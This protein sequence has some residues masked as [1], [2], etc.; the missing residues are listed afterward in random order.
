MTSYDRD[1]VLV[2]ATRLLRDQEDGG[3]ATGVVAGADD[4]TWRRI[5]SDMRRARRRRRWMSI[6]A[7]QFGIGLG[8]VGVWAA[9]TGRL[10]TI[11]K[12]PASL[13]AAPRRNPPP[14]R[15]HTLAVAPAFAPEIGVPLLRSDES[16]VTTTDRLAPAR[17]APGRPRSV[18]PA[19][20][21][22]ASMPVHAAEAPTVAQET[23]ATDD[24]YR[25]A[26][27]LHFVRRDFVAALAAWDR[28]LAAAPGPLALEG[29][30]NRA[31]ALVHLGRRDE[32]L[33]ALRPFADGLPGSYRRQEARAL[34]EK[35]GAAPL[36]E[37]R[38]ERG[39]P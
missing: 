15:L 32:A 6:V 19:S 11:V 20:A 23:R 14:P 24:L 25:Q 26:H 12:T 28:Y 1:D 4:P 10:P 35:L 9:V 29:R 3:L 31:I 2:R 34:M 37:R 27:Q 17:L 22:P 8:S 7:L 16:A 38:P 30:Y 33:L 39:D 5:V 21:H 18:R 36:E 13:F